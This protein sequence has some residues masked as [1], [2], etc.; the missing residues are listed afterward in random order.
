MMMMT[1]TII[2]AAKTTA[3]IIIAIIVVVAAV[4]IIG[5]DKYSLSGVDFYPF[6]FKQS[7]KWYLLLP[8]IVHILL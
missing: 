3:A 2:M 6:F 5:A 1:M 4:I 7:L 8:H